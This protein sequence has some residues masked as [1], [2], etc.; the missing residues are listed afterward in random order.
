MIYSHFKWPLVSKKEIIMRT[1]LSS[2]RQFCLWAGISFLTFILL[3]T[4]CSATKEGAISQ[5]DTGM[6]SDPDPKSG[7]DPS[8]SKTGVKRGLELFNTIGCT[9]CHKVNGHGGTV[10]P[11][12]SDEGNKGRSTAWLT[13]QIRNPKAND[14][15]TVMP[16]YGY[17]SDDKVAD[18]IDYLQS[19]STGQSRE[20]G[21][22]QTPAGRNYA[23]RTAMKVSSASLEAGEKM[24]RQKCGQCHNLRP[25]SEYSDAQWTAAVF[26]MRIRVPLTGQEQQQILEFLK[27]AN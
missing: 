27:A 20:D 1:L 2:K 21:G 3:S 23:A 25:P 16:A 24:W 10:G 12:L 14:P 9:G 13:R 19:L 5:A 26:H 4:G 8:A 6:K 18:L 22:T 7:V 11:D 15:Q 17:L